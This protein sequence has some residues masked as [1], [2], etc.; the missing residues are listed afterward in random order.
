MPPPPSGLCSRVG[1]FPSILSTTLYLNKNDLEVTKMSNE[2]STEENPSLSPPTINE[3]FRM[4][5]ENS[6]GNRLVE[7]RYRGLVAEIIVCAALGPEWRLCSGDWSGWDLEHLTGCRLD[8]K[9]SAAQQTWAPPK[10]PSSTRFD[11]RERSGYFEEASKRTLRTGRPAHIYVFAYHPVTDDNAD[12]RDA[13]QWQFHVAAAHRL[14]ASQSISLEK[15]NSLFESV[16]WTD[17]KIVVERT[18]TAL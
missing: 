7:N 3:I 12:H 18:R 11:I 15:V 10:K 8:V 13:S 6:Y 17:L 9:Q 14:P 1:S 5:A 4:A 2:E 16:P